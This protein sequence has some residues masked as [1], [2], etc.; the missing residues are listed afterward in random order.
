MLQRIN[1]KDEQHKGKGVSLPNPPPVLDVC[2]LSAIEEGSRRGGPK[3]DGNPLT[4]SRAKTHGLE[5]FQ[6]LAPINCVESLL[7][8]KLQEER[9][10]F[11]CVV[12]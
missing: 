6:E 12:F 11:A 7:D 8:V 9:R 5:D 2:S 4:P 10:F 3:K 1:G